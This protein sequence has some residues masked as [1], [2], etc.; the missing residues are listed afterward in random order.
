MTEGLQHLFP[1]LLPPLASLLI[2]ASLIFLAARF[3]D[4]KREFRLLAVCCV[5]VFLGNLSH[6]CLALFPGSWTEAFMFETARPVSLLILPVVIHI[7]HGYL[8][9]RGR[10]AVHWIAYALAFLMIGVLWAGGSL[11]SRVG[12]W[13]LVPGAAVSAYV[14]FC[15]FPPA[16]HDK[17][18]R[19]DGPVRWIMAS[20][21]FL[22]PLLPGLGLIVSKAWPVM[23][24]S[25]V[26]LILMSSGL[27]AHPG[28][29]SG[30]PPSMQSLIRMFIISFILF[31]IICDLLFLFHAVDRLQAGDFMSPKFHHI[32]I[33]VASLLVAGAC[34]LLSARKIHERTEALL[35]MAA[36]L[37]VCVLNFRDLITTGLPGHL[38]RQIILINDI[39]LVNLIGICGHMVLAASRK[40]DAK[41]AAIFY[42]AGILLIPLLLYESYLG[43]GLLSHGL[44]AQNSLG[45]LLFIAGLFA[46]LSWCAHMLLCA[47]KDERN[48]DRRAGAAF[49][50]TGFI[51]A[52]VIL[53]GSMVTSVG[54]SSY[55]FYNLA[56]IPLVFVGYGIFF[57]DIKRM[58]IHAR[59]QVVSQGLRLLI[60]FL[61]A[62]FGLG[63]AVVLKDCPPSRIWSGIVPYGI[64]PMLSFVSA[65]FLSLFVLGLERN[66]PESQL[67]SLVSF[68]YAV[69]NLDI[70]LQGIVTDSGIALFI[71]RIDHFFLALLSLGVNAHLIYLVIGKKDNWWV[72]YGAYIAGLLMAPWTQTDYY[73]NG[74]HSYFF[75]FFA[76]KAFLYDI[77]SALWAAGISYGI[78]L[79]VRA[80]R[81]PQ[82]RQRTR[83]RHVLTA[84]I[85]IAAL[86][87]TNNPA[88]YGFEV[89]P[90]GTFVFVALFFLAYGLFK[91]NLKMALQY[92]RI[93]LFWSGLMLAMAA[94]GLI[95]FLFQPQEDAISRTVAGIL[96]VT[97]L[98][99]PVKQGWNAVLNLFM[100]KPADTLKDSYYR[101]TDS[102]TRIHH[103][104]TIHQ[105]LCS[106]FFDNLQSACFVSLFSLPDLSGKRVFFGWKT[107]NAHHEG[108]LFDDAPPRC[109]GT[110]TLHIRADHPLMTVCRHEQTLCSQ[111]SLL[112]VNPSLSAFDGS[113][114]LIKDSEIV[115]PV[116]SKDELLCIM[117][118]GGKTDGS[119]YSYAE[120]DILQNISLILGP[121]IENAMLMEG[122][123]EK[124]ELRTKELNHALNESVQKERE[125]RENSEIIGRQNQIFR[126]LLETSTRIHHIDNLYELFSF[127]LSQLR[128]LFADF[129]GGIILE[130]RRR[131]I[132][133]ATSFIGITE[134]E[135]KVI[136][137]K[138]NRVMASDFGDILNKAL[139]CAGMPVSEDDVWTVFPMESRGNRVI[140]YMIIRGQR[141]DQLTKEIF[142]VFLGQ[143]SAVTQNKLLMTQLE[144]MASTDGLTGLYNRAFL[145][146]ELQ[147]VIQHARQF[148]NIH[149]SIMMVDVNGL[150]KINDTYG[151]E[152]GDE[153]IV[154]TGALLKSLCRQTDIVSRLG[155][156]EFAIL[157]PSTNLSQAE[158]LYKR[159]LQASSSL[160][161]TVS[162]QGEDPSCIPVHMSV[163]LAGSDE[164]PPEMVMKKADAMM[165]AAK[166]QYYAC[167]EMARS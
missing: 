60:A 128:T 147:K 62:V 85:I 50:A 6:L 15:F 14:L 160:E 146:Q 145:N 110:R 96:L 10:E 59:R 36:C 123:E 156:D 149:F 143:L 74:T 165:Y 70:F 141:I 49:L 144:R 135:Q 28:T 39:F 89:Y 3:A 55:P 163:G 4:V 157:M 114:Q 42:L 166:E 72:V 120:Y 45:H 161:I 79:L 82:T 25:F 107:W 53:A 137:G 93:I 109:T 17:A 2:S 30:C 69:L 125:I 153:A 5:A 77:M 132:L 7:V 21:A 116:M 31:P 8:D 95:P 113:E 23:G 105:M 122:L 9:I 75:G 86:S 65:G 150:K 12:L 51:L 19:E 97:I 108:G 162:K 71:S 115:I 133:E 52:L 1:H 34:A 131:G 142:T 13:A 90:L 44:L 32:V 154:R 118:L 47:R 129:R 78:Y 106:W 134:D 63:I 155:G 46:G 18:D 101:L 16:A 126:T 127:I 99:L 48:P 64:P 98:F 87:I 20:G 35:Y 104:D 73:F 103:R 130:D 66:R 37:L 33:T 167:R 111:E 22:F 57:H 24:F 54:L 138:R 92:V 58:G 94:A 83:V 121:L 151:H 119:S 159:I 26:P 136:L 76:K 164:T 102:L 124:V 68:C 91:F 112:R 139:S 152:K 29:K 81:D 56:S 61:Y 140:G 43:E 41:K 80:Y 117:L 148:R 158:I 38:S 84:F 11:A 88:I 27:A 67:F 100:A 40:W